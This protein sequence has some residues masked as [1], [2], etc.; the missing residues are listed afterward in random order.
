MSAATDQLSESFKAQGLRVHDIVS[1]PNRANR[2]YSKAERLS[3]AF[4]DAQGH[5]ADVME[6]ETHQR[7]ASVGNRAL[8]LLDRG[9]NL[10]QVVWDKA[11]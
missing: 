9:L 10:L 4:E 6:P 2:F 8:E 5:S 1:L 3:A 7:D 11:P